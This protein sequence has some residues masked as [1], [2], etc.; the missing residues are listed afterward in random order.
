MGLPEFIANLLMQLATETGLDMT[1]L[2]QKHDFIDRI[3]PRQAYGGFLDVHC[4]VCCPCGEPVQIKASPP[5]M[6]PAEFTQHE[7]DS[8]DDPNTT[9][10]R[11]QSEDCDDDCPT[12]IATNLG[13]TH[14]RCD[15]CGQQFLVCWQFDA[16]VISNDVKVPWDDEEGPRHSSSELSFSPRP[17]KTAT[18]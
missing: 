3:K 15:R 11:V 9:L 7:K 6:T 5:K 12:R 4:V 17:I 2:K 10:V 16:V 1:T 18:H 14:R 8:E 13:H